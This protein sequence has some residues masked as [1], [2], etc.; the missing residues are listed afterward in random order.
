MTAPISFL[1]AFAPHLHRAPQLVRSPAVPR[2]SAHHHTRHLTHRRDRKDTAKSQ[3]LAPHLAPLRARRGTPMQLSVVARGEGRW[4]ARQAR[5]LAAPGRA[6]EGPTAGR[7]VR[8]Q[9]FRRAGNNAS[10]RSQSPTTWPRS[11]VCSRPSTARACPGC[12]AQGTVCSHS[13]TA[14]RRALTR[15]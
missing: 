2:A 13:W 7:K 14:H 10:T 3:I 9:G 15:R 11:S 12:A 8:F 5:Q 6:G 4:R 1:N